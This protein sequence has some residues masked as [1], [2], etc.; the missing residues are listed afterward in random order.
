MSLFAAG[1][2]ALDSAEGLNIFIRGQNYGVC[3]WALQVNPQAL[4]CVTH[5]PF[6]I[7]VKEEIAQ[8]N[9]MFASKLNQYVVSPCCQ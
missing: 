2:A 3:R 1:E 4:K 9:Q 5:C 6:N 7:C 8:K